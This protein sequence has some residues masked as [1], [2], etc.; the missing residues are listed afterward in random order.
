MTRHEMD[1][2]QESTGYFFIDTGY[3]RI[4]KVT[5]DVAAYIWRLRGIISQAGLSENP[6]KNAE[7]KAA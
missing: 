1:M 6:R 7:K 4:E 2:K 3:G 5:T